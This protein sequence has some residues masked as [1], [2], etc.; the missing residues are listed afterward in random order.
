MGWITSATSVRILELEATSPRSVIPPGG[1]TVAP[2]A[3]ENAPTTMAPVVTVVAEGAVMVDE[4]PIP[5]LNAW[6]GVAVL[7]PL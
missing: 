1:V 6:T 2:F 3:I 5:P 7:T 4:L